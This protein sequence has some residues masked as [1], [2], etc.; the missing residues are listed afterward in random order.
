MD[1]I[2]NTADDASAMLKSIGVPSIDD[3]FSAIPPAVRLTRQLDL[4]PALAQQDLIAHLQ[5]LAARNRPFEPGKCFLGAGAYDPFVPPVVEALASRGEFLSSYTPYQAEASQGTLQTIFEFQSMICEL[6]ELDVANAS[7]YDGGTALEGAVA[8]AVDRTGRKKVV[9]SSAVNPQYRAVVR[10]LF[11]SLD[12]RIL[13]VA[14]VRGVTPLDAIRDAAEGAACIVMQNP[15][16][17][18]CLEDLTGASEAARAAGAVSIASVNPVSLAVLRPPGESGCDIAVGEAQPLGI[19]MS[20]GGPWAGFIAVRQDFIR[21]VPGRIVGQTVDAEGQRA[22]CLTLQTREQHIRR[23]KASSNICTNQALMALRATVYLEA[24]GP[25]GLRRAAEL[26]VTRAHELAERLAHVPGV[27][28][29]F[30]APFFHEFV[31]EVPHA[32]QT[33]SRLA[34]RGFLGGLALQP[35]YPDLRDHLLVCCTERHS[36]GDLDAF[37]GALG[38]C[39]A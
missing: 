31:A 35:F 36:P 18:G 28:L 25:G 1:Y 11:Q 8:M 33:L 37:A 15:N 3:L 7:H 20:F 30:G 23:E 19:D 14:H 9:L 10:S 5:A 13:E 26:A 32:E 16:F 38:E 21:G 34:D 29:P 24:L 22:Y 2:Q 4:P 17:L 6:T 39:A 12:A 27:K